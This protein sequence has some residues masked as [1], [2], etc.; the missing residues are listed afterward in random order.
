MPPCPRRRAMR[1]SRSRAPVCR[2]RWPP[3]RS[4]PIARCARTPCVPS[5]SPRPTGRPPDMACCRDFTRTQL[6]RHAAAEAGRGLPAI[7]PG[8]RT[9]AG[10]GLSRRS[11]L[12]R[13][14]GS[15]LAGDGAR[16]TAPAAPQAGVA[17]AGA[18][19]QRVLVSIFL[20]G[21]CDGMSVLAPVGDPLYS[22]LR[23]TLAVPA[24]AGTPF[25]EDSRLN[26][27]PSAAGLSTLHTE[28]KVTVFPAIG[29][30]HPDQS[31]FT[32]RHFW[33]VG[34][35]DVRARYGWLGRYLDAAG[36]SDN[37]LQGLSLDG[38]L[39]PALAPA[40]V[41]VAA[42]ERPEDFDFWVPG[43]DDPV[44]QSMFDAFVDLGR[45]P[46]ND[47]VKAGARMV[48]TEVDTVRRQL[49]PFATPDGNPSYKSPVPYPDSDLARRLGALG[50]MLAAG[51]PLHCVT[52]NSDGGFDTHSGQADSLPSDI[53]TT[54][55][56]VLAFQRDLESRGLADRVLVTLWSE[57]GR[58]PEENGSGTDHGAGGAAL[59]VGS[60]SRRP[61]GGRVPGASA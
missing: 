36:A 22:Q 55:D 61:E 7:E 51:L 30:D 23:P 15:A 10:T 5:S 57:F 46:T 45:L 4:R 14:A 9:P 38:E 40:R 16:R 53:K 29:Y 47:P 17:P 59:V 21:G 8:M 18:A 37:P 27:S 50:A 32:S 13:G 33:E 41:P 52:I 1:C 2:P 3:G 56:A 42:V 28:G 54:C 25:A 48:A 39:S 31:H 12:V 11:F 24:S 60:K 6:I 26:W 43:V 34:A 20:P 44:K 35:T 19:P 49:A 58:R